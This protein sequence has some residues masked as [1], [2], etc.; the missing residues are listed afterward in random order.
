[1]PA[2]RTSLFREFPTQAKDGLNGVPGVKISGYGVGSRGYLA[3][4]LGEEQFPV[5]SLSSQWAGDDYSDF[6]Y[7]GW[8]V[9]PASFLRWAIRDMLIPLGEERRGHRGP[10]FLLWRHLYEKRANEK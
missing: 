2:A 1:M 6:A 10:R 5:L 7:L 9:L 8:G 4:W 3:G